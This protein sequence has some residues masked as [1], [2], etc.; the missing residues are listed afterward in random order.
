MDL[1]PDS[2]V[3]EWYATQGSKKECLAYVDEV[4]TT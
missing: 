1:S 2:V 4:W 3:P